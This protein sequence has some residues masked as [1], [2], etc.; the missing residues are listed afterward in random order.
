MIDLFVGGEF[1]HISSRKVTHLFEYIAFL[2][3]DAFSTY[4]F[5]KL[6]NQGLNFVSTPF[7]KVGDTVK[8]LF[9]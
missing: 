3:N 4:F 8:I 2:E 6:L 9:F 1:F 7:Y 5:F